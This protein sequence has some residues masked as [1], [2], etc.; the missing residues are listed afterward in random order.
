[1][2]ASSPNAWNKWSILPGDT[3]RKSSPV[4]RKL[5]DQ[6]WLVEVD[7]PGKTACGWARRTLHTLIHSGKQGLWML[8][9]HPFI[10][11]TLSL[12]QSHASQGI[13]T[14]MKHQVQDKGQHRNPSI[15]LPSAHKG[16]RTKAHR[17]G[18]GFLSSKRKYQMI[19]QGLSKRIPSRNQKHN[20]SSTIFSTKKLPTKE[21][22]HWSDKF[23]F[24]T[25]RPEHP[26]SP[27]DICICTMIVHNHYQFSSRET[28]LLGNQFS[29]SL[30]NFSSSLLLLVGRHLV[31]IGSYF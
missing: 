16:L 24:T 28:K 22:C 1:M 2:H 11:N 3:V 26:H 30:T 23:L 20:F 13:Q 15:P 19:P 5:T 31:I 21:T 4:C 18:K 29:P 17:K 9:A 27:Y 25:R 6:N 14:A 7:H 12:A 8:I 10:K